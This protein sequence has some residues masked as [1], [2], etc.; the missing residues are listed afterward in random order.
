MSIRLGANAT[1]YRN[2]NSYATPTWVVFSNVRDVDLTEDMEEADAT[3]RGSGKVKMTEP[4]LL[5]LSLE[6]EMIE[7]PADTTYALFLGYHLNRTMVDLTA[8]SGPTQGVT[9]ETFIRAEM[10]IIGW[11]KSEPLS[12]INMVKVTAKPCYSTNSVQLGVY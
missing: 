3:T 4:T 9:G 2:S 5:G 8:T 11:K 12:G 10:K 1:M 6:W 7:D